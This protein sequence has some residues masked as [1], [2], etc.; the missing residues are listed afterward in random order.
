MIMAQN[1]YDTQAFFA[2][3]SRLRRSTEGLDGAGEWPAIRAL[4]PDLRGKSVVDLGCGFGWFVRWA[5]ANGAAHV[6][7]FDLSE[8]MLARARAMTAD[9]GV[10]D[11]GVEYA[12]ADLE[13]L[14]LPEATFDLAYSSLT[15]HYIVDFDRLARMVFRALRPGS[16]F[17]FT[18]EHPVYMA[19]AKPGWTTAEDGRKTWPVDGYSREGQRV[20]DWLAK[21]VVKQH[22]TM[23]TT[24]NALLNAGFAL[25]NVTEWHPTPEQIA[26]TPAWDEEMDRP[27]ILIISAQR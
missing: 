18:I 3:Y 16:H 13:H 19:P 9:S 7:G 20:T 2:G 27:M 12:F 8:N 4:L 26:A 14:V 25:R 21:G 5:R 11:S 1:I 10:N 22:R 15:F 24:I 23:G 6:Q 17:V